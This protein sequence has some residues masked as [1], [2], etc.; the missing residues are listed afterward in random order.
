M[1]NHKAIIK[2][3][4]GRSKAEFISYLKETLIPDLKEDGYDFTA[5]DLETCIY[6]MEGESPLPTGAVPIHEN[7]KAAL[8]SSENI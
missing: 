2:N 6:F 4:D 7:E 8:A 1:T 5:Q 3:H